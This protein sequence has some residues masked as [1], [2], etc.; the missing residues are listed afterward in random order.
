MK[1]TNITTIYRQRAC[2]ELRKL[3]ATN[4]PVASK[5]TDAIHAAINT[6]VGELTAS[7][8]I[9]II[10][11]MPELI[12]NSQAYATTASLQSVIA[13]TFHGIL[14]R[15]IDQNWLSILMNGKP[16]KPSDLTLE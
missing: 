11:D 5:L 2:A 12:T 15:D 8:V 14:F 4:P 9:S 10:Q 3:C 7:E 6:A 1:S 16:A 13:S